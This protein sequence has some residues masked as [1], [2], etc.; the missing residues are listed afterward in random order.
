MSSVTAQAQVIRSYG[1]EAQFEA[2][3]L[4]MPE[5][6]A[7]R[8]VRLTVAAVSVNPV[9]LTTRAGKNIPPE[10]ARFPMVLGWDVAGVVTAVGDAVMGV[11]VGDRVAAM[12]FQA[13][14]Q[15]GTY[16]SVLDLDVDL[17][18]PVPDGLDLRVAATVPLAGLTASE[19]VDRIGARQGATMLVNA[20]LGA[21]GRVVVQLAASRGVRV[22]GIT[23]RSEDA[24]ALGAQ[25]VL[26]RGASAD[27][28]R[29][30][31]PGDIDAAV[32]L[33]GGATARAAFDSVRQ[34]G[35]YVTVVPPYIDSSGVFEPS[36]GIELEV[37]TVH[38][39]QDRLTE[40]LAQVHEGRVL[41]P[42]EQEFA[43]SDVAAAHRRQAAGGLHGKLVLVP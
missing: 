39:D 37:V 29:A 20:P 21:V 41:S 27:D 6:P 42:I 40:L 26:A 17:V 43:L 12:T 13:A 30:S 32:D 7:A 35:A 31:V 34:G 4:A 36:R 3:T 24:K 25:V 5:R 8:Q 33:V 28:V 9:D 23:D 16:R 11:E 15:N 1:D 10:A 14:D 19:I 18:S 38:P 2:A 22:V